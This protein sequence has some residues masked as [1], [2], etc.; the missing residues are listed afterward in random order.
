[1]TR[2]VSSQAKGEWKRRPVSQ[3][4]G[5]SSHVAPTQ[6]EGKLRNVGNGRISDQCPLCH[7]SKKKYARKK[8]LYLMLK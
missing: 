1:M 6:L 4:K 8:K 3:P 5:Q 2:P 7:T